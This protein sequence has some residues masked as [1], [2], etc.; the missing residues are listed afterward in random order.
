MRKF[1]KVLGLVCLGLRDFLG[2]MG[3]DLGSVSFPAA[4]RLILL[5]E[6]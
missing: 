4:R 5:R 3:Q 1:L 6:K 2:M